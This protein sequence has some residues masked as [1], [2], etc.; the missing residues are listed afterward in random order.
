MCGGRKGRVCVWEEEGEGV[1]VWKKGRV[2]GEHK[3]SS[4]ALGLTGPRDDQSQP[5]AGP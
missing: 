3:T 2:C 4:I 1:C 5:S